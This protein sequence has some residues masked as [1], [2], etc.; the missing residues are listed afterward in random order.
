MCVQCPVS[1]AVCPAQIHWCHW[2]GQSLRNC[3]CGR[4]AGWHGIRVIQNQGGGMAVL[5]LIYG[6]LRM[7]LIPIYFICCP[8]EFTFVHKAE[9]PSSTMDLGWCVPVQP[10]GALHSGTRSVNV[11]SPR[12][13]ELPRK[14]SQPSPRRSQPLRATL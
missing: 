11:G 7:I 9:N 6:V 1:N 12:R 3:V 4:Y 5:V 13:E 2:D 14:A 8:G 10:T